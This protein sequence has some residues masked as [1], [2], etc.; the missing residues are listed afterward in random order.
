MII[1]KYHLEKFS[2]FSTTQARS[3]QTW[4]TPPGNDCTKP[5]VTFV[6]SDLLDS[7]VVNRLG[8]IDNSSDFFT[9]NAKHKDTFTV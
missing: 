5:I 9:F 8:H 4:W 7:D 2:S 6:K 1:T 3:V